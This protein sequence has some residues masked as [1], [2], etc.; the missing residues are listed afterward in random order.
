M[1]LCIF[2]GRTTKD[3]EL[4]YSQDNKPIAR[5][6][7]A[8]DRGWGDNKKT[9]FFNVVAFGKTAES[10]EKNV[11][12]GTKIAIRCEAEQNDYTD[13]N[14][15]THRSVNFI[16]NDWEFCESK[17]RT[18]ESAP[19]TTQAPPQGSA[20]EGFMNMDDIDMSE[21]PFR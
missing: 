19:E 13:N 6:S 5:F 10:I 1:D 17:G 18:Q 15:I 21:L 11:K 3:V 9:S 14:G 4:R 12:K 2:T 8:V 7:I 20:P 16:L